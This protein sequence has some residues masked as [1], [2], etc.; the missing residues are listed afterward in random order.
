MKKEI[1]KFFKLLHEY[2]THNFRVVKNNCITDSSAERSEKRN[3]DAQDTYT[4]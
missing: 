1:I 2:N 4:L 3:R